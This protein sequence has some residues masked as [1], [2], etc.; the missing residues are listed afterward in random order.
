MLSAAAVPAINSLSARVWGGR[1][2]SDASHRVFASPRAVR[3][4]EMEYA[5]PLERFEEAFAG[6]RRIAAEREPIYRELA[7]TVVDTSRTPM[8]QLVDR[9][10]AWLAERGL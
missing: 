8:A 6:L 5:V 10:E 9:L 4:R 7:D 2:F 3:F 1:T